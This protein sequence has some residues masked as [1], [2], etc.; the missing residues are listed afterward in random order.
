LNAQKAAYAIVQRI[1]STSYPFWLLDY[2]RNGSYYSALGLCLGLQPEKF[3]D[4]TFE[5]HQKWNLRLRYLIFSAIGLL[6]PVSLF[7]KLQNRIY[8]YLKK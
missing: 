5:Q 1:Y 6:T 7:N 8:A 3:S 2:R 4:I